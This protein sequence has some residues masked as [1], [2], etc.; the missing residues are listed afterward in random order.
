MKLL[1]KVTLSFFILLLIGFSLSTLVIYWE[2]NYH[3]ENSLDLYFNNRQEH[4]SDK[5]SRGGETSEFYK[6]SK[7]KKLSKVNSYKPRAD[8]DT[9]IY[10]HHDAS[11]H[12]VRIREVI[13]KVNDQR[14]SMILSKSIKDITH[15]KND[16]YRTLLILFIVLTFV[17]VLSVSMLSKSLFSPFYAILK[18]MEQF[19]ISKESTFNPIQTKTQ[20]FILLQQLFYQM[21]KNVQSDY[22]LLKEYTENMS[23]ELQTPLA[24]IRN[25]TENLIADEQVMTKH[26]Q[27]V[28][29]IHDEVNQLSKLGSTLKLLTKIE[30]NEFANKK[31][32]QSKEIISTHI[33]KLRESVRLKSIVISMNLDA[34]HYF[35][36]DPFLLEI[37]LKNL[38]KNAISYAPQHSTICIETNASTF[39]ISNQAFDNLELPANLFNRFTKDK[40]NKNSL[41][42]GL[43]IVKKICQLNNL[44]INYY[45]TDNQHFLIYF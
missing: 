12:L 10:N 6:T 44:N 9:L 29:V 11:M 27:S 21:A 38:I 17:L 19:K 23:H 41:G 20:E 18:D 25:K 13:V 3:I 5:L 24:I 35:E 39:T 7:V 26:M 8:R 42:L 45:F 15:L 1:S 31:K 30:N 4:Y 16:V 14:Y 37:L 36:I 32:I 22:R 34:N 43:S 33:E 28:K 2:A 40:N